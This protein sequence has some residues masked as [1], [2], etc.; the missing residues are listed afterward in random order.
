MPFVHAST[1]CGAKKNK[2]LK[3]QLHSSREVPITLIIVTCSAASSLPALADPL[4]RVLLRVGITYGVLM[5]LGFTEDRVLE[6]LKA[7]PSFE[8]DEAF[9]WVILPFL[10]AL[11]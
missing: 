7:L 5:R 4:E 3:V 6:C 11:K 8:L 2:D 10:T 1:S 9:D